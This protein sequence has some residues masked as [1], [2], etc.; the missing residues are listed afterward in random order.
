[1]GENTQ[2]EFQAPSSSSDSS[3]KLW[4]SVKTL[5]KLPTNRLIDSQDRENSTNRKKKRF[6]KTENQLSENSCSK[7]EKLSKRKETKVP[8]PKRSFTL[9]PK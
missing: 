7:Y 2:V 9:K 6:D 8:N 1:M 4:E 3:F 5:T